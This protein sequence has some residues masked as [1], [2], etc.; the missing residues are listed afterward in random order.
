[1]RTINIALIKL[2]LNKWGV[3]TC[4]QFLCLRTGFGGGHFGTIKAKYFIESY[5]VFGRYLASCSQERNMKW[6]ISP[7]TE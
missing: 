4:V 6:G 7:E 5:R 2:I 1:V 3:R